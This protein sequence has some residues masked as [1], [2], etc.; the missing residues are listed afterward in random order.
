LELLQ[1][2]QS[3]FSGKLGKYTQRQLHLELKEGAQPVHCK[4]YPVPKAHEQFLKEEV[5]YLVSDGILEPVGAT[6]HAYPTFITPKKDGCVR[7]VSDFQK[8]NAMLKRSIYPLSQIHDILTKWKGYQYFTKLDLSM[9]YYTF[10][11][12]EESS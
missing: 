8:L 1:Q 12:D 3:L 2:H 11:L 7:W 5:G 4:P 6:E 10:E 9:Q